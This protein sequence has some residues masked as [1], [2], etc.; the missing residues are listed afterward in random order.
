MIENID[1]IMLNMSAYTEWQSGISNRNFNVLHTLLKDERVRKIVA[2][3]YLPF[4]W[5]RSVKQWF[6]N[7][8]TGVEGK[9]IARGL[10][11]KLVAASAGAIAQTGY[12][13]PNYEPDE[14]PFT[15]FVYTD[16]LASISESLVWR[17]LNKLKDKL[18]LKNVV[19]WSYLP[20][21][22]THYGK[23]GESLNVFDAVDNWLEH[24]SY[25]KIQPRLK[26]NY[27][28]IK[29]QADAIFT[30]SSKLV[31]FFE[32]R[33]NCWFIPNGVWF[34]HFTEAPKIVGRDILNLPKPIIGY[35]GTIQENRIDL[36]LIA[37]IAEANPNKS[38]VMIGP[39]WPSLKPVIDAKLKKYTNVHFLGRK[40]Y[41]EA[42]A[43][44]S[45]FDVAIIPHLVNDFNKFTDPLKLYD[46]LSLG[47]PVVSTA[48]Q[49]LEQFSEVVSIT[50]TPAEFNEAIHNALASDTE[51][52]IQKRKTTAYE[53]R[54]EIRVYEMLDKIFSLINRA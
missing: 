43:Y 4:N 25:E 41:Q 53:N 9:V 47:K 45:H 13:V 18:G 49:G 54:W 39:V 1:V 30:T 52:M 36:D 35:G 16:I 11:Y 3:D 26:L 24:A 32:Q 37:Y 14:V 50:K 40:S 42:P 38:I 34:N 8:M 23:L 2:V 48:G 6:K 27:Q 22:A 20:T 7:I 15:L 12:K 19:V 44:Y 33:Q 21:T 10:T 29:N 17:R 46:Y 28:T 5:R 31:D 51:E